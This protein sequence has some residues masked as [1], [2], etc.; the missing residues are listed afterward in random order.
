MNSYFLF[1]KLVF[2]VLKNYFHLNKFFYLNRLSDKLDK[3][4]KT[5]MS[6]PQI[7]V[8]IPCRNESRYISKTIHSILNQTGME[9]RIEI[10]VIDGMSTDSTRDVVENLSKNNSIVKLLDN[11]NL[12]TPQALNIGIKNAK[13]EFVAI[14]G[15]HAEYSPDYLQNCLLLMDEHPE[16]VCVGGPIS[17]KGKNTFAKATAEAMSSFIGVGNANHRFSDYEGYA[18]MACFPL[19]RREVFNKY[20]L[21]DESL[22]R[23]QDDEFCFRLSLGGEKTFISPKAKS[24]YFVRESPAELFKQYFRYGYWRVAVLRKHKIPISFRQQVPIL[25]YLIM[26]LLL[27]FGMIKGMNWVGLVLPVLYA[28]IIFVFTLTIF[29][30]AGF[31]VAALFPIPVFILHLSYAAGFFCGVNKF[32]IIDNFRRSKS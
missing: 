3:K 7:T 32:L 2:R 17:S 21:Y 20:G 31:T 23:N 13:G 26:I 19:F 9:G 15:A 22:I 27:I 14:L 18:E 30:K 12:F 24:S 11:P 10:L 5:C 8:I 25:F 6:L 28:M 16:A 29:F 1:L 4:N